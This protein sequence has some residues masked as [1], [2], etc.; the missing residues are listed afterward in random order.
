MAILCDHHIQDLCLDGLVN[1]FDPS[2]VNPASL[3]VRLASEIL[4]EHPGGEE[5]EALSIAHYTQNDPYKLYPGQFILASTLEIITVPD[6]T[7]IQFMLKSSRAREG[8]EHLMA[9]YADSGFR[10]SLTLELYNARFHH[11]VRLWPGMRIGQL[12]I[13][14]LT[15]TP[16]VSYGEK[17]HYQ[18][19]LKVQ[20]SRG[21]F[22]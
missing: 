6:H 4:I 13:H 8:I 20:A 5:M 17:G 18:N 3:D 2:L 11:P 12:V 7:A 9:G 16:R 19:D 15:D 21:H 1:P 22:N 10:G 14:T